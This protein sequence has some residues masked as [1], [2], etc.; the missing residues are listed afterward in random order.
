MSGL[1]SFIRVRCPECERLHWTEGEPCPCVRRCVVCDEVS[2]C[3]CG[4]SFDCWKC[5][6]STH[7]EDGEKLHGYLACVYCRHHY[8]RNNISPTVSGG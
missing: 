3:E 2:P 6:E 5:R 8:R 4:Q 7:I 1:E